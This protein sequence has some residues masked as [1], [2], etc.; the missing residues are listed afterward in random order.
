MIIIISVLA[1][2]VIDTFILVSLNED[3][4]KTNIK[5]YFGIET[6]F[7][8]IGFLLGTM[9]FNFIPKT[10]FYYIVATMIIMTQIIDIAD[11]KLPKILTPILLGADSLFIFTVMPW[12]AIPILTVFELIAITGASYIGKKFVHKLPYKEYISNVVM[13]LIA[14]KL[15]I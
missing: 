2:L 14:V 3:N 7:A 8:T 9:I 5:H 13:T 6:L 1:L 4:L 11:I 15:I 12:I 10:L